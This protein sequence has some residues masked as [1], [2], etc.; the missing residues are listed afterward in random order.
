[1][2]SS[3]TRFEHLGSS[4]ASTALA[5]RRWKELEK[6]EVAM[7]G[8]CVRVWEVLREEIREGGENV[9]WGV[10]VK[11]WDW[12]LREWISREGVLELESKRERT[13]KRSKAESWR[14]QRTALMY[15]VYGN[16]W[17][18]CGSRRAVPMIA[19][20]GVPFSLNHRRPPSSR[21]APN[22]QPNLILSLSLSLNSFFIYW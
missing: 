11:V 19:M 12:G 15:L 7:R 20:V 6:V 9:D 3:F 2:C 18:W 13:T 4:E 5:K 1:M 22:C 8:L 10:R 16:L 14:S 21:S 17:I